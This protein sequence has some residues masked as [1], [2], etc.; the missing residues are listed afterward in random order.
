M[1][2]KNKIVLSTLHPVEQYDYGYKQGIQSERRRV[3]EIIEKLR[4]K[5]RDGK[6]AKIKLR[7]LNVFDIID[8]IN[9]EETK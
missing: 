4:K 9:S 6:K 7:W 3:C 8:K 5:T 1:K 2:H